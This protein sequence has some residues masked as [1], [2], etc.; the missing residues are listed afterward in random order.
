MAPEQ[1]LCGEVDTRTDV[2]A[3]GVVLYELTTGCVPFD[4]VSLAEVCG[5]IV[6]ATPVPPS[7]HQASLPKAFDALIAKCLDK[8]PAARPERVSDVAAEL[9]RLLAGPS[10][11]AQRHATTL[12]LRRHRPARARRWLVAMGA[13]L[14][15]GPAA[16][17]APASWDSDHSPGPSQ[18]SLLSWPP[19]AAAEPAAHELQP[20]RPADTRRTTPASFAETAP[21]P[22]VTAPS[23][24]PDRVLPDRVPGSPRKVRLAPPRRETGRQT[25]ALPRSQPLD[26]DVASSA[27]PALPLDAPEPGGIPEFGG[28][29]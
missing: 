8:S 20:S 6:Q 28:R 9:T 3:L 14:A 12:R 16:L 17:Y 22:V 25:A 2:W 5:R 18:A 29:Y 13:A 21:E 4:G 19:S 24:A 7:E 23:P 27:P 11:V 15:I 1:V 26:S 10:S